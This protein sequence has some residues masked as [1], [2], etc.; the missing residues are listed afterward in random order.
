MHRLLQHTR[1]AV[2]AVLIVAL[3]AIVVLTFSDVIGRR[4]FGA[5]IYGAHDA[6][7]HLMAIIVFCG[8]PLLTAARGHLTVDLFDRFVLS[9][10]MRWWRRLVSA[11]IAA[12]LALIAYQFLQASIEAVAIR[13]I[14]QELSVPRAWMYAF[15][16]A[17][18]L[19]SAIAA[20]L[21]AGAQA[22]ATEESS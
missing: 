4:L 15:M 19:L 22:P 8:L 14:S 17:A 18:A 11:A 16:A 6:T 2:E 21:P 13:E 7:E 3:L 12:T 9:P 1:R 5:P 10:K 20:L